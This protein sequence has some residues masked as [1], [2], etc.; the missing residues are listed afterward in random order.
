MMTLDA[1]VNDKLAE[2]HPEQ[3]RRQLTVIDESGAAISFTVERRDELSCLL[4]DLSVSRKTG[5]ESLRDSAAR[6]AKNISAALEPI[7]VLEVDE[8]RQ[9]AILRSDEPHVHGAATLHY[10]LFLT[11]AK[12]ATLRRFKTPATKAGKREQAGFALT[13]EGLMRL[14]AALVCEK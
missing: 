14:I 13:N 1:K 9:E 12:V 10:E 11:G 3:G 5:A 8:P 4:W 6:F 2:W 7:K